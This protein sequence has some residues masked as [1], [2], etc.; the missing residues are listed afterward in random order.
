MSTHCHHLLSTVCFCMVSCY[1]LSNI[2]VSICVSS[3]YCLVVIPSA[4]ARILFR[5]YSSSVSTNRQ[6]LVCYSSSVLCYSSGIRR[7]GQCFRRR[8]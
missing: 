5:S 6:R 2:Q 3:P 1:V 8:A 7:M 4:K